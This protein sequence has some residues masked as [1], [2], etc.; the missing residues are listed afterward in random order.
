MEEVGL[1]C[2][3]LRGEGWF[4]VF[5]GEV[6]VEVILE[7]FEAWMIPVSDERLPFPADL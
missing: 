7:F 2:P 4:A 1:L 3:V 6:G 5:G